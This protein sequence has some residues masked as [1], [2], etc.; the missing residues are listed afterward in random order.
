M[1]PIHRTALLLWAALLASFFLAGLTL[2]QDPQDSISYFDNSAAKLFFFDDSS[3]VLYH[4]LADRNIYISQ[5][6]GKSW[7]RAAD[8]PQG[9]A[10]MLIEHPFDN[11]Y[12]FVMT[13]GKT[14]YRTSDRGKTWRSFDV[15][16]KMA[17]TPVPLSFHSDPAKY[18]NI[19]YQ[20]AECTSWGPFGESCRDD[21]YYTLDAFDSPPQ[22]LRQ[23]TARCVFAHSTSDFKHDA[24]PD[25]VFCVAFDASTLGG[26]HSIQSSRLYSTAD[27]K[28]FQLE[29]F[30]IGKKARGVT[31]FAIV[32]KF[33]VV[34][35][36]DEASNTGEMILY[37][38]MD[39]NEWAR[40]QFP[41][42]SSA[43]LRENAYTIV[44]ST[45]HSLAVDVIL[46]TQAAV[47]TLFVSNSNG[48]FFVE[49]LRDTNRNEAGYVDYE[50][51]YGVEGI[52]IAN[53]VS[54]AQDVER[55]HEP[56]KLKSVITFDD[57]ASWTPLRAPSQNHD[58]SSIGCN[59]SDTDACS[60]HL[61]S[62]TDSRN[63]GRVFSSPAP[64]LV[65]GVGSVGA[66]LKPY[67]ECDT[68][69]STDGGLSWR[70]VHPDAHMYEF[71]DSGSVLVMVNDEEATREVVYSVDF[72]RNWKTY[73]LP[74]RIRSRYL[75][76]ISDSTSQKF[77]L[78]GQVAREDQQAG[79]GRHAVVFLDF[80]GTRTRKCGDG[81]MERW[82]ARSAADKECLMGTKQYYMRRKQDADCYVGDKFKDPVLEEESCACEDH[83][84]ECDYNFVRS[85]DGC[86]PSGPE[87]VPSDKCT[88]GRQDETYMGSSGYRLIPGNKCDRGRGVAK[89]ALVEKK[90]SEAQPAEGEVVHS[91][92]EFPGK[93]VQHEF[94]KESSVRRITILVRLDDYS[95]WQSSNEGYTWEQ[96][97]P[98]DRFLVF[99]MH[100]HTHDRAY[101]VTDTTKFYTTTDQGRS[102][103]PMTAP[104]PPNTFRADVLQFQ[105]RSDYLIW[106][107]N[108]GCDTVGG[109]GESC[110]AQAQYSWNNGRDWRFVE[111]YV[112]TC[113]W[114]RDEE[115]RIDAT[116]ILC[117]SWRDKA[118][119]Q[120]TFNQD[121]NAMQLVGGTE[122]FE[123]KRM[124]FER[125]VGFT[126]FS[127]YLIVA[128]YLQR[129]NALDLQVS[130]DGRTFAT[131]MFPPMFR[132][133]ATHA[134]T[135]LE[136]STMSIFLHMTTHDWPSPWGSILKS[137]S[138][139]TYFGVSLSNVNRNEL[140]YVDFEK[141]IGLDG[142]AIVNIVANP[143]EAAIT[144]R[145]VLQSRITHNDGGTWK[146]LE[147]PKTDS[148]GQPYEC[149]ATSCALH[150]H[151]YTE[152]PDARA[153]FSSPSVVGVIMGVG[154]VGDVLT[155]YTQ[156]STFLS[157]D[158]G[159][160]WEEV[161]KD[162]HLW[163]FGDSGALIVVVNDEEPTD[164][165]L[166]TTDE[167]QTWREY[168]FSDVRM[169]VQSIV[170][171]PEDTSRK[172]MLLARSVGGSGSTMVYIDFTSLTHK[173]C[174][175]DLD[176]PGADDFELWSPSEERNEVCLFGRQT[177]YHRRKRDANC[178]VGKREKV[179]ESIQRECACT[180]DDFECEFNYVKDDWGD[181]VPVPGTTALASD[182]SCRD[183]EDYWYDRTPYRR[184]PYSSCVGGERPDRGAAHVCP[185][186][187][188]HGF[189]FWFWVLIFPFAVTGTLTWWWYKKSG[190]ARGTIRL[191]GGGERM[192]MYRPFDGD[193]GAL[194]TLAS[195]PYFLIGLAGIAWEYTASRMSNLDLRIRSRRGYR[196]IPVDEDAQILRFEDEE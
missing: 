128:E 13:S 33:A 7:D 142:I 100:S 28:T 96:K 87:R 27:Y 73:T 59:P 116:Q 99:Y 104:S 168:K 94:F 150:I 30:G 31:A 119:A 130:L 118:G 81:D 85:G 181:C 159:F 167:G 179:K 176:N 157:R 171:V 14:H 169:R 50:N 68:F 90:C 98:G 26:M 74:I 143:A 196:N 41:H 70:M 193:S 83:D 121:N 174:V 47:G 10:A 11:K 185:G 61:H 172:F 131:G 2:A 127:E 189:W 78:L 63:L 122:Y 138:N 153:T 108:V 137:N 36:R 106:T 165:V 154:N 152:R 6:E 164:H 42:A 80:A 161:H 22:L 139:G 126:K 64:G 120:V 40:A 125:V 107:G 124:L 62:V 69:L 38:T 82:Y 191:P 88:T 18:G 44:E 3:T 147:P 84:F 146:P 34:A 170:T 173:Q 9:E 5:D 113:Q 109:W 102:W 53:T 195:V 35:I 141:L 20:G 75:T 188:A 60:L 39:T 77:V 110:R 55:K 86:V 182:D 140:G 114:A 16:V 180:M 151:G 76:T 1:S 178:V 149:R 32:G 58:G 43:S 162:A 15:P 112:R 19:L 57:G 194:A 144:G 92:F 133:D 132:P 25:R 45:V 65:M 117:E 123:K 54:N 145:K 158:G 103:N 136:S 89:D 184:I 49:S 97:F 72:G 187:R 190:M 79:K 12:A 101:L 4:D 24:H 160:T 37:V 51:I 166:F 91:V 111:D 115:L 175:L 129:Q 105:P 48:T 67:D 135:V 66:S 156:S 155:P 46:Q 186:I 95:I 56:K 148:L 93:V 134:Y 8:I 163:E 21:T 177:L 17:F 52:G 29:E 192:P 183:D 71:G 23:D